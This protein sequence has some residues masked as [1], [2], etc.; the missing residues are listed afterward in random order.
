[1]MLDDK[2]RIAQYGFWDHSPSRQGVVALDF[3]RSWL[4]D[5]VKA[6]QFM[7]NLRAS[8]WVSDEEI[9][10]AYKRSGGVDGPFVTTKVAARF[11]QL[12]PLIDGDH[13]AA[14]LELVANGEGGLALANSINF[15]SNSLFC[16]HA[17][18]IDLDTRTFE[19]YRGFS[20]SP[21]P[22]GE[23]FASMPRA[24]M[25]DGTVSKYYPVHLL[26]KFSLD[27]LPS[28]AEF[29]LALGVGCAA[30]GVP[31]LR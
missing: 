30:K 16:E 5:P 15:A 10:D 9:Q 3:C 12:F 1:M 31:E 22:E 23:R 29:M 17:Y 4:R 6:S 13:G 20:K 27:E 18:V 14:I 7:S 25:S 11:Q 2:Y 19:V 28:K 21:V 26:A 8:R 24:T